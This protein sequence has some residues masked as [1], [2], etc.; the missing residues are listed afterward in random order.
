M[1][2]I[3]QCPHCATKNRV[4]PAAEGVPRCAKCKNLLPWVVDADEQSFDAEAH[5]SVPAVV[6]FWAPWCA[7]CRMIAPVLDALA[8]DHAGHLKVIRVNVDENPD[9]ARR[10]GAM[11]IPLLVALRDGEEVERVV[12]ALPRAQLEQRL[13]SILATA[14]EARGSAA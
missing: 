13:A 5:A 6:D 4:G 3:F 7:P 1:A 8:R 2:T 9:L 11:S 12:G 14:G 10:Y